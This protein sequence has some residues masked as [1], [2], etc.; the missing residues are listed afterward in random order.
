MEKRRR[1]GACFQSLFGWTLIPSTA[2]A[3]SQK[4]AGR[5][6]RGMRLRVLH[7]ISG[8]V[9]RLTQPGEAISPEI[10]PAIG[11]PPK[12][13]FAARAALRRRSSVLR[14]AGIHFGRTYP[15]PIDTSFIHAPRGTYCGSKSRGVMQETLRAPVHKPGLVGMR[16]R[17]GRRRAGPAE[18]LCEALR[19]R[20]VSNRQET[21]L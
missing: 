18:L 16:V 2:T 21:F 19:L 5:T 11:M 13:V 8:Q 9:W 10:G 12:G 20:V 4:V 7:Q 17:R 15:S 6:V 1:S 3:T 14:G